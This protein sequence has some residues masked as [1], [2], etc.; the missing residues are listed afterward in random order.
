MDNDW[1]WIVMRFLHIGPGTFW[2]GAS[3]VMAVFLE[4]AITDSGPAGGTVMHNLVDKRKFSI[5]MGLSSWVTVLA[6][7]ALYWRT[8]L[9]FNEDWITTGYG[10]LLTVGSI[11]AII[12]LLIGTFGIARVAARLNAL[13]SSISKTGSPPDAADVA[14][15]NS[16]QERLRLLSRVD[17][18]LLV[19]AIATMAVA[20]YVTF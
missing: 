8:S 10:T 1:Y 14:T 6:G 11:A 20:R 2:V 18:A 17:A 3:L 16:L 13:G 12:A 4:P 15:L 19:V 9:H 7:A 5:A